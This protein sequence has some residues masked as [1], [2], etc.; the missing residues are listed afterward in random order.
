[1]AM[2]EEK[3]EPSPAFRGLLVLWVALGVVLV[4]GGSRGWPWLLVV[5]INLYI[6]YHYLAEAQGVA[7][8]LDGEALRLGRR[9]EP[10]LVVPLR[11]LMFCE[12]APGRAA[13]QRRLRE[14]GVKGHVVAVPSYA[15]G[16][17]WVLVY[18]GDRGPAAVSF[19]PSQELQRALVWAVGGRSGK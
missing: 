16:Q 5:A 3:P 17:R 4:A 12:P 19:Y 6:N 9:D 1:L 2:R 15:R 10:D 18:R 7:Y 13:L 8:R 11:R 14:V